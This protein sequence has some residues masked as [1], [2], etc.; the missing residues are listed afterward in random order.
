MS[1]QCPFS[2]MTRLA[3]ASLLA[4]PAWSSS[5]QTR[6]V[7]DAERL[8]TGRSQTVVITQRPLRTFRGETVRIGRFAQNDL[9]I[10]VVRPIRERPSFY[11]QYDGVGRSFDR[12]GRPARLLISGRRGFSSNNDLSIGVVRPF[13][14][15]DPPV[16]HAPKT[17]TNPNATPTAA[18]ADPAAASSDA[19][20]PRPTRTV[21]GQDV[22]PIAITAV[23]AVTAVD[24]PAADR[25]DPWAL[26]DQGHYR[27]ARQQFA[28]LGKAGDT[29]TRT[30]H[31]LAAALSGDLPGGVALMPADPALPAGVTLRSATTQRLEQTRQFL[32]ADQPEM[33]NK[34]QA[35]IDQAQPAVAVRT[36]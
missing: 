24:L 14:T 1:T 12:Q 33:Q 34:L 2:W 10:G 28:L 20:P 18:P 35:I 6:V 32:Y 22:S 8:D 3:A 30:G 4:V 36:P 17:Y 7:A 15:F 27:Q 9:S 26:L 29:A 11:G 19:S 23:T 21:L 31:A 25:D 16:R 5:G 13:R